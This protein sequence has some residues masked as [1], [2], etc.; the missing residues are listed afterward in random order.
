MRKGRKVERKVRKEG[1]E[2]KVR[3]RGIYM[4]CRVEILGRGDKVNG[5]FLKMGYNFIFI[6]FFKLWINFF[7]VNTCFSLTLFLGFI[8]LGVFFRWIVFFV[9]FYLVFGLE[10]I[11]R[12][13]FSWGVGERYIK[14][15]RKWD[16][17]KGV[18]FLV[19]MDFKKIIL[20]KIFFFL[21]CCN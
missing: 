7:E 13:R 20:W 17:I 10:I 9:S 15:R 5:G 6:V 12:G 16:R 2:W 11:G 19:E 21:V 3:E 8:I 14:D 1:R 18:F 4:G